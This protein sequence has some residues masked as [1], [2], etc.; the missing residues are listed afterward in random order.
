MCDPLQLSFFDP[1]GS[2]NILHSEK[3]TFFP[4]FVINVWTSTYSSTFM[5]L[6]NYVLRLIEIVLKGVILTIAI[7]VDMSIKLAKAPPWTV[8]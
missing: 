3:T 6:K 1:F 4:I 5:T 2:V 8:A 7:V